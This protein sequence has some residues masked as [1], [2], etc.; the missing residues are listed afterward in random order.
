MRKEQR[1]DDQLRPVTIVPGYLKGV[2]GSALIEQGDTRVVCAATLE[3]RVPPFLKGLGKGWITAEYAM[4]P[5]SSG[6]QRVARE[7]NKVNNRFGEIQRFVSR[8]LRAAVDLRQFGERTITV[9]ADVIQAD[10]STR[11]ASV[12]GAFVSLLLCLKH[13]V[14]EHLIADFPRVRFL[15]AVSLGVKEGRILA[16]LDYDEDAA[17]DMDINL[18]SSQQGELIQVMAFGE[19]APLAPE[20]FARTVALGVEKNRE[21]IGIIKKNLAASGLDVGRLG[22]A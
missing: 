9:D 6:R 3:E 12:N 16:D 22:G 4:L 11:C 15:A 2:P 18:V 13:L 19:G 21:I 8:A 20:L 14:F 5:G 17:I 1:R 7:R 10:G